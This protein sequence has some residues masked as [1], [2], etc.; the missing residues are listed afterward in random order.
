[1]R[2][3]PGT[4]VISK[5]MDPDR[6]AYS[7]FDGTDLAQRLRRKEVKRVFVGGLAM[8]YCVKNTVLDALREGFETILLTDA[9]RGV[10]V[11]SGDS[12]RAVATMVEKGAELA[13]L[14]QTMPTRRK[15]GQEENGLHSC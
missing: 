6:E 10:E 2:L 14:N 12:E 5:A 7:G 11:K 13:T 4:E 3:P 8:D 1:M 15:K 9:T